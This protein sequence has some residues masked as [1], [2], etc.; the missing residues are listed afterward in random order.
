METLKK[1]MMFDIDESG[2]VIE[3]IKTKGKDLMQLVGT[4]GSIICGILLFIAFLGALINTIYQGIKLQNVKDEEEIKK[5][6]TKIRWGWIGCGI[7]IVIF[8]LFGI[9][10]GIAAAIIG[11]N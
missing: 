6:R 8:A 5:A 2:R 11:W 3:T 9:A 7:A 1:L 10:M 4:W